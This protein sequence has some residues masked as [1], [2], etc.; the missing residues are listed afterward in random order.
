MKNIENN[1]EFEDRYLAI[2]SENISKI[3]KIKGLTI[4]MLSDLTGISINYLAKISS[5]S[6]KTKKVP[7]L[8]V[9]LRIANG[10]GCPPSALLHVKGDLIPLEE[11][12][13]KLIINDKK[14]RE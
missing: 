2:F 7:T 6:A 3:R 4:P 10:L 5:N 11:L 1:K 13:S 8:N 9:L 12:I 14:Y